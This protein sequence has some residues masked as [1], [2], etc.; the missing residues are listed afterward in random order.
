MPRCELAA[1]INNIIF[2]SK[3]SKKVNS[4]Q[5]DGIVEYRCKLQTGQQKTLFEIASMMVAK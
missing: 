3:L 1:V 2:V 5:C 4:R